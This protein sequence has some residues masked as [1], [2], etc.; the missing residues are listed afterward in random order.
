MPIFGMKSKANPMGFK[1][2]NIEL[3]D[4]IFVGL[5]QAIRKLYE[6]SAANNE[7]MVISVNGKIKHVPAKELLAK[8]NANK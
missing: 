7:M 6:Q 4:K 2:E 5:K 1:Q 3:G 8:M